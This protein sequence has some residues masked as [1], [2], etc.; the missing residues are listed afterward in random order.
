M[1]R[2]DDL[3]V[4][5]EIKIITLMVLIGFMIV[6]AL[7][8]QKIASDDDYDKPCGSCEVRYQNGKM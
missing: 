7:V 6:A 8:I 2:S 3:T 5:K 1:C 4:T